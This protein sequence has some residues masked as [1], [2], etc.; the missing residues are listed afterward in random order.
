MELELATTVAKYDRDMATKSTKIH[1]I[2]VS[3][4]RSILEGLWKLVDMVT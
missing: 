3:V 2:K 1:E 4:A